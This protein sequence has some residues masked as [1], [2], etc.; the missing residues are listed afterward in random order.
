MKDKKK[1]IATIRAFIRYL[2]Q[3]PPGTIFSEMGESKERTLRI[4][5]LRGVAYT[6]ID[7]EKGLIEHIKAES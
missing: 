1:D 5:Q 7:I 2:G 6:M 4:G 3:F